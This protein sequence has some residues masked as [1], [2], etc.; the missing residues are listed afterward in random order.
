MSDRALRDELERLQVEVKGLEAELAVDHAPAF[1]EKRETLRASVK[2]LEAIVSEKERESSTADARLTELQRRVESLAAQ[3]R[4]VEQNRLSA[5]SLL[6]V[7]V[8]PAFLGLAFA[9]TQLQFQLVGV[10]GAGVFGLLFGTRL[11]AWAR[12][13]RGSVAKPTPT[14]SATQWPALFSA[15]FAGLFAAIALPGALLQLSKLWGELTSPTFDA[16]VFVN[17]RHFSSVMWL[18]FASLVALLLSARVHRLSRDVNADATRSALV[19]AHLMTLV[20]GVV[21]LSWIP[22]LQSTS[23]W[24]PD[25]YEVRGFEMSLVA[26]FAPL[27]PAALLLAILWRPRVARRWPVVASLACAVAAAAVSLWSAQQ[28]RAPY[29]LDSYSFEEGWTVVQL[30]V[31]GAALAQGSWLG[32][33]ACLGA[34]GLT[35]FRFFGVF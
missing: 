16:P 21:M 6:L 23:R 17:T 14:P 34:V 31:L 8:P 12:G 2:Q 1:L 18:Q 27:I 25:E 3:L 28:P 32:R 5:P 19:I 33:L 24:L 26:S 11:G 9:S 15:I 10:A 35:G 20:L 4:A 22:I 30:A 7:F 13:H 29:L